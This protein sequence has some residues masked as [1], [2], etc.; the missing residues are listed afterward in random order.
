MIG[1][2]PFGNFF[3]IIKY[4]Y[5]ATIK[6]GQ[7]TSNINKPSQRSRSYSSQCVHISD[8]STIDREEWRTHLSCP[9]YYKFNEYLPD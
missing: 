4:Y 7:K 8:R 2:E 9:F 6:A 1:G 3:H 5:R